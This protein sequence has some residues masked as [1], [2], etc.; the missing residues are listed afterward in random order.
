MPHPV[1]KLRS[2]EGIPVAVVL[3]DGSRIDGCRLVSVTG[4]REG[5]VWLVA[6]DVDVIVPL[7]EVADVM[8]L[9]AMAGCAA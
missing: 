9:P 4:R 8:P 5:S 2:L 3:V 6:D 1:W 7:V